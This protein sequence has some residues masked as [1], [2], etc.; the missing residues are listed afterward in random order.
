[1]DGGRV[2]TRQWDGPIHMGSRYGVTV[3]CYGGRWGCIPETVVIHPDT[4][5]MIVTAV[6]AV[7]AVGV[8]PE[9]HVSIVYDGWKW[10][11]C[12]VIYYIIIV[13]TVTVLQGIRR[14][15]YVPIY[16]QD[17]SNV[18]LAEDL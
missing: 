4:K 14:S 11:R 13:T 7:T 12:Y 2:K 16:V 9:K 3:V 18:N 8:P 15:G 5:E 10:T 1:M 6:T 17:R